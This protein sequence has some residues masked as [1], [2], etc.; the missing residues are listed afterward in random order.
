MSRSTKLGIMKDKGLKRYYW[1]KVRRII[2]QTV[3]RFLKE[4]SDLVELPHPKSI[5]N[6]YDYSDY[7]I[8]YEF[9]RSSGYFWYNGNHDPKYTDKARRK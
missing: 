9:D 7:T 2:N 5:M 4:D 6:D 3:K 1:K 8:D